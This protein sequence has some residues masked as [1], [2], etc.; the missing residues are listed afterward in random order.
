VP[1]NTTDDFEIVSSLSERANY[2]VQAQ[3][4]FELLFQIQRSTVGGL[5]EWSIPFIAVI[6]LRSLSQWL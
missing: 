3:D 6:S 2:V 1:F 5:E 4:T